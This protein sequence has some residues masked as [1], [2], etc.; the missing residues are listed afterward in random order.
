MFDRFHIVKLF[1]EKLTQLRRELYREATDLLQKN[2]LKGT[3]WLLMMNPENLDDDKNERQR[4]EEALEL[5]QPLAIAYYLKE[6]LRQFWGQADRRAAGKFLRLVS[7]R[8]SERR[9]RSAKTRQDD[10]HAPQRVDGL[11][12]RPNLHRAAGRHQQQNQTATAARLRIPRPGLLKA[13][14]SFTA[15]HTL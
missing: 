1:N 2:V 13:P 4:L 3:R 12:Y 6:D 11:V 9:P 5:N 7:T 14:H 8:R 10:A 15:S